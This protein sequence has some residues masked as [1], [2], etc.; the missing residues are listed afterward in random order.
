MVWWLLRPVPSSANKLLAGEEQVD[1]SACSRLLVD[2]QVQVI[3]GKPFDNVSFS[4]LADGFL[5]KT[6][7]GMLYNPLFGSWSWTRSTSIN[8]A[9]H[10]VKSC[11]QEQPGPSEP[12]LERD[13]EQIQT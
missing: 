12:P 6:V 10:A 3:T 8:Y 9:L 7:K 5:V 4:P 13:K 1:H 2:S 11:A